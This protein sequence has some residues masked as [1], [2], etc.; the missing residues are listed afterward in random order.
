[1]RIGIDIGGTKCAVVLG[2]E[3][4]IVRK[5]KFATTSPKDTLAEIFRAVEEMG[6]ADAIGISCG[7][8]LDEE[9]GIIMSPPNLVGWDNIPLTDMLTEKFGIP[10]YLK[11]DANA[12]ALAEWK[13]GAGK[14][15]ENMIFLTFG[16]GLGAGLILNG[17]LYSG[18]CAMAGEIG[19]VRLAEDGPLGY[20]KRGSA[21]GFCSGGGLAQL[22]RSLALEAI[23][24]GAAPSFCKSE[25]ELDRIDAALLAKHAFSGDRLALEAYRIS[26]EMLGRTLALLVDLLNPELIVIGSIFARAEE[27]L[28]PHMERT[29]KQEALGLSHSAVR[30]VAAGLGEEIGDYAALAVAYGGERKNEK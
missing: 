16:T 11:N 28:R 13:Y 9:R 19:H 29:L 5:I 27:L 30:V 17:A 2:N 7:G 20:G 25:E 3:R 4:E 1:M 21:E 23:R 18:A 15:T 14:G 26:G 22:G 10:A 12:C 6:E 8:P 24:Q